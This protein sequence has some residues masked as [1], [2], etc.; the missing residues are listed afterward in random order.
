M[1]NTYRRFGERLPTSKRSNC[2]PQNMWGTPSSQLSQEKSQVSD[3]AHKTFRW[4]YHRL[5]TPRKNPSLS[6]IKTCSG[7]SFSSDSFCNLFLINGCCGGIVVP[8]ATSARD[9]CVETQNARLCTLIE[10]LC[11][12]T[13]GMAGFHL[14]RRSLSIA[15]VARVCRASDYFVKALRKRFHVAIYGIS[16]RLQDV[17]KARHLPRSD[18]GGANL[19]LSSRAGAGQLRDPTRSTC[20]PRCAGQTEIAPSNCPIQ[21]AG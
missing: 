18:A 13:R 4:L 15:F 20:M 2:R 14:C 11:M 16:C 6:L 5:T 9:D 1:C 21:L 10:T 19:G 3:Q 7:L 12:H 8:G 17:S